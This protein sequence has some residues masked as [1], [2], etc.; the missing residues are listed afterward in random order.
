VKTFIPIRSL[1]SQKTEYT[2]TDRLLTLNRDSI[3]TD[4]G[5]STIELH[6]NA[7]LRITVAG[8]QY[9]EVNIAKTG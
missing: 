6:L 1:Q 4:V 8:R 7:D 3:D 9:I 5:C 2:I